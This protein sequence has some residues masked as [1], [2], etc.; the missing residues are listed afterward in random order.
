MKSYGSRFFAGAL[1]LLLAGTASHGTVIQAAE[2]E[3][4]APLAE[5]SSS[6]EFSDLYLA[7]F[8]TDGEI[9]NGLA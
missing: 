8:A 3:N 5:A 4:L 6:S 2:P 9:Q 7:R 1:C